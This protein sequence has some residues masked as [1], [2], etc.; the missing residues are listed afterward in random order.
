M[1]SLGKELQET[2]RNLEQLRDSQ[3]PPSDAILKQLDTL[4]GQQIELIDAAINRKSKEYKS[5]TTAMQEAA[6]R[7]KKAIDDLAKLEKAIEK[8]ANAIGKVT[9]LLASIA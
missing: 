6:Q 8:V 7:T 3:K 9:E 2:I 1:T 5:A 4:Y